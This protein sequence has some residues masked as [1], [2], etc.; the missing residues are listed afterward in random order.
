MTKNLTP[1]FTASISSYD[2]SSVIQPSSA[3]A[4][5]LTKLLLE[6]TSTMSQESFRPRISWNHFIYSP[7]IR[8]SAN[9]VPLGSFVIA[10]LLLALQQSKGTLL[11]IFDYAIPLSRGNISEA[12]H[13][14]GVCPCEQAYPQICI[15]WADILERPPHW[16]L[17]PWLPCAC[18]P[19][20]CGVCWLPRT[21]RSQFSSFLSVISSLTALLQ[22]RSVNLSTSG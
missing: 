3:R 22:L 7:C 12:L 21:P 4:R 13:F 9:G 14:C 2:A 16:S 8:V 20:P 15:S 1:P 6:L 11:V 19:K 17:T 18:C 5:L 10:D